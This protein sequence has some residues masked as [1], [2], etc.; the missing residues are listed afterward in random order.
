MPDTPEHQRQELLLRM[1]LATVV[2]ATQG[3]GAVE[4]VQTLSRA[5]ALCQALHDDA[6]LVSVLVGLG[7]YD[8]LLTDGVAIEQQTDE[9]LRLLD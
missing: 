6:T 5:W 2:S 3:F 4:L 9:E 7:R 1:I 8:D